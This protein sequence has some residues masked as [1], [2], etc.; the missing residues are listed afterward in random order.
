MSPSAS[1]SLTSGSWAL[2][3]GTSTMASLLSDFQAWMEFQHQLAPSSSSRLADQGGFLAPQSR[4]P[5]PVINI[6]C[7]SSGQLTWRSASNQFSSSARC[8]HTPELSSPYNKHPRMG[9]Y[10]SP[11]SSNPRTGRQLSLCSSNP[12]TGRHLSPCRSKNNDPGATRRRR[13]TQ[14]GQILSVMPL[15]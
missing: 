6:S 8:E 3:L 15:F 7:P 1:D 10:L 2:A 5:G 14:E 13:G 11:C 9:R 4:E 12:R